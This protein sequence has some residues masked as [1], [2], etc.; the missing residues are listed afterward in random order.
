MKTFHAFFS[1]RIKNADGS[2]STPANAML[3][4]DAPDISDAAEKIRLALQ[5][6]VDRPVGS[7]PSVIRKKEPTNT[8]LPLT[9]AAG[10]LIETV[11]IEDC[12]HCNHTGREPG[13]GLNHYCRRCWGRTKVDI[14][15]RRTLLP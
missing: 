8:N 10:D 13:Y 9:S 12:T 15:L 7:E 3:C 4:V 2:D 11:A 1:Y 14:E 5:R 6:L